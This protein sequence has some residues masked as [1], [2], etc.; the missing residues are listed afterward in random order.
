MPIDANIYIYMYNMY[1]TKVT[2]PLLS[3]GRGGVD[4]SL[5]K[6]KKEMGKPRDT[7]PLITNGAFKRQNSGSLKNFVLKIA[8]YVSLVAPRKND[9]RKKYA[10]Y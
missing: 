9:N 3:V 7:K 10:R 4:P 5:K 1:I 2:S 6:Y 8:I